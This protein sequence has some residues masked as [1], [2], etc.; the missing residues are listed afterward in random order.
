MI[1]LLF[2]TASVGCG[3]SSLELHARSADVTT[4]VLTQASE[5]IREQRHEAALRAIREASPD[6]EAAR[7][8][9]DSIDA[10]YEPVVDVYETL[11][12]AHLTWVNIIVRAAGGESFDIE[13][14]LQ[15]ARDVARL[16][17]EMIEVGRRVGLRLPELPAFILED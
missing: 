12:A 6:Q 4:R 8:A 17:Q 10:Q 1:A 13:G 2:L 5:E 7:D 16:Y 11:R 9:R 15:T 14:A 3:A